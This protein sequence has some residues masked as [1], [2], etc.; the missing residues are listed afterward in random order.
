MAYTP[1]HWVCGETITDVGLNNIEEGIQE[2]LD[3]CGEGGL[4]D[5]TTADN[6]KVLTV[7]N[8]EWDKAESQSLPAVTTADNDKT[9]AVVNGN[10]A[11]VEPGYKCSEEEQSTT[12]YD[13]SL[14]TVQRGSKYR[15][16]FT[17]LQ[18]ISGDSITVTLNGTDYVLPEN[19]Y[20]GYGEYD[21]N[22]DAPIFTTYPCYVMRLNGEDNCNFYTPS[23]GTYTVKIVAKATVEVVE[24]SECFEKAVLKYCLKYVADYVSDNKGVVANDVENNVAGEYSFAEGKETEASGHYAHAEGVYSDATGDVSHAEGGGTIASGNYAHAEGQGTE[25]SGMD[26]HAEGHS[27]KATGNDAH[28][29]GNGTL[30]SGNTS[31]AEG[32]HTTAA[33]NFSHAEGI[34]TTASHKTQHVFGEYN[35][36]DPST[37]AAT[38]RGTYIEIVGNGTAGGTRSNARTLDWGGNEVLKGSL[39]LGQGTADETT[40]T[41]AQLKALI[42]L[43][44]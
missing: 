5:V 3:C 29:E 22:A 7:V 37:A 11:K 41:A 38:E 12:N 36:I 21:G 13:G 10:W 15:V 16:T 30:A 35:V 24:T 26:S 6:G 33:G 34:N 14:T 44:P 42:A 9:L 28:A 4:P 8:G 1:K 39:T 27:T 31:H 32:S 17:P 23:A 2:A 43:L 20:G 19:Q 18:P 25:S 40:V